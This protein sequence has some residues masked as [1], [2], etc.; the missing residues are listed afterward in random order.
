MM[1]GFD[2]NAYGPMLAELLPQARFNPLDAGSPNLSL[3]PK[4]ESIS[5]EQAFAPQRIR[6]RDMAV[7]CQAALW[8]GHNFLEE[9]HTLSQSLPS[10]TGSYWHGLM[11]RREPD[12]ANA[13]YWFRRV[14]THPVFAP[15]HQAAV[16]LAAAEPDTAAAFLQTQRAWDPFAF[17]D[18]CESCLAGR[19]R[20]ERL[21]R[22]VQ[23]REWELLFDYCYRQACRIED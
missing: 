2:P 3:R 15:L 21:C 8:L 20:S 9:S 11:H 14:G 7:A 18:L 12:F 1:T 13:K 5:L 19:S 16:Q 23:Q 10:T 22:Q 4:L 17:I 6:D